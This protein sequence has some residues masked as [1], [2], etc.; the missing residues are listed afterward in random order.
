GTAILL[1]GVLRDLN[2]NG[3]TKVGAGEVL[4]FG[5]NTY[6]GPTTV[7]AGVLTVN[8]SQALG[9]PAAGTTV[10]SGGT[11]RALAAA[12]QLAER[13]TLSGPGADGAGALRVSTLAPGSTTLSAPMTLAGNAVIRVDGFQLIVSA[14][15][16][17][18][19][20]LIKDG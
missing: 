11:L 12:D 13:L 18:P 10:L 5:T 2:N 3:F 15:I 17:G 19:G 9:S 4:L 14:A 7:A 8:N 20:G 6:S 1:S 16:G